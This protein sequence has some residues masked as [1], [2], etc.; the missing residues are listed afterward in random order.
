M[1]NYFKLLLVLLAL[2]TISEASHFRFGTIS[3]QLGPNNVVSFKAD[4]AF[5]R[6]Y[7][8]GNPQVGSVISEGSLN[9][10][11]KSS[12]VSVAMTVTSIDTTQD[13]FTGTFNTQKTYSKDGTY[14]VIYTSCCRI[15]SLKNEADGNWNITTSV[16]IPKSG[17]AINNSPVSGMLPIVPVV[18]G[19][20][21][22]FQVVATDDGDTPTTSN[23]RYALTDV[24]RMTQPG[25]FSVNST[26]YV[27]FTPAAVGLY[28]TQI[29]ITDSQGV[30]IVS[31]FIMSSTKQTGICHPSCNN[32]GSTCNANNDCK[33][34]GAVDGN[35]CGTK[36]PPYFES[37]TPTDGQ[38]L[39][40]NVNVSNTVRIRGVSPYATKNVVITTANVPTGMVGLGSQTGGNPGTMVGTWTPTSSQAG[41][42]VVS[43]GLV[44]SDG[45]SM[46]GGSQSFVIVVGKPV[47]GHGSPVDSGCTSNCACN[48]QAGWDPSFNCFECEKGYYGPECLPNPPCLNGTSN[49]GVGGDGSCSCFFGYTGA[50][51]DTAVSVSCKITDPSSVTDTTFTSGYLYPNSLTAYISTNPSMSALTLPLMV[52]VPYPLPKLDVYILLDINPSN[53][54][55]GNDIKSYAQ[56]FL[57]KLTA[58]CENVNF[59]LGTFS[60]SPI[61]YTFQSKLVIGSPVLDD[62]KSLDV[63]NLYSSSTG[64]SLAAL[65]AAASTSVGWNPG[66]YR[67]M[68]VIT[69]S[70]YA[71]TS[72]TL[73]AETTSVLVSNY[74]T[75]VVV[76]LQQSSAPKWNSFMTSN[77]FG[78]W[79]STSSGTD[80][81]TKAETAVKSAIYKVVGVTENNSDNFVITVPA[82]K[83]ISQTTS[84][85]TAVP[86]TLKYP[87]T[88]VSGRYPTASLSVIGYGKTAV[89]IGYNHVPV[90]NPATFTT[91]EDV[92]LKFTLS[93]TDIDAN[94]LTIKFVSLNGLTDSTLKNG[95]A[96]VSTS[97]SYASGTQFTLVP[98]EDFN[99]A[100]SFTFIVNDGCADSAVATV[101]ITINP[102][103]DVPLCSVIPA[104]STTI[105][106]PGS[107]SLSG[108]DVETATAKL[109]ISIISLAGITPYGTLKSGSTVLTA[110]YST[111]GP[112]AA[113]YTQTSNVD[114]SVSF[115]YRVT[116]ADGASIDCTV[117]MTLKHVNV[118]PTLT[119]PTP[120]STNP[121]NT[122]T[123]SYTAGD[124]DSSS[125]TLQVVSVTA[126]YGSF[127]DCAATPQTITTAYTK[128]LAISNNVAAGQLCYYA[129][130]ASQK[131]GTSLASIT[132]RVTDGSLT[133][134]NVI[135][136]V[137]VVGQRNNEPPTVLQIT[138]KDMNQDTVSGS[139]AIDGTDPDALD[140]GKLQAVILTYPANGNLLVGSASA[141]PQSAAPYTLTYKP[142]AGWYG[143]DSFTYTVTDTLGV[144]A[145]SKTTTVKVI[146]VNHQ[147][148]LYIPAYT[149]TQ[150]TPATASAFSAND[151]DTIDTLT[152]FITKLPTKASISQYD[153][154]PI[155]SAS[156][157]SPA[158][159]TDS[160]FRYIITDNT[161]SLVRYTDSF[162]GICKD[163]WAAGPL[164]SDVA[165]GE[166]TFAYINQ[167]PVASFT[168]VTLDQ[169][170]AKSFDFKVTDL[171]D[172]ALGNAIS[173]KLLTL[174]VNGQLSNN[175][176]AIT[177]ISDTLYPRT[178]TYTPTGKLSNWD[179]P[180]HM[181]PL[182]SISYLAVDSQKL[183]SNSPANVHFNVN[184]QNP[185]VYDG[186]DTVSTLE[187][188]P[189]PIS[190]VG[191]PGNG[192]SSYSITVTKFEGQGVLSATFCMASGEGCM[193][194]PLTY[195]YSV[196]GASLYNFKYTP[197]ANVNGDKL[198][199]ISF[200]L[201][202]NSLVSET[203]KIYVDVIPVNDPPVIIMSNFQVVG[204]D[205]IVPLTNYINMPADSAAIVTYTGYDIDNDN[206]TLVSIIYSLPPQDKGTLHKYNEAA[207]DKIGEEFTLENNVLITG[208]NHWRVVYVPPKGSSGKG[209]SRFALTL[210]DALNAT[211]T[212]VSIS[213]DV[214]P[215]NVAPVINTNTTSYTIQAENSLFIRE[216]SL[217]DP[218]SQEKDPNTF[219]VSVLNADGQVDANSKINFTASQTLVNSVCNF[220]TEANS[221]TCTGNG[222]K[223]NSIISTLTTTHSQEATLTLRVFYDDLGYRGPSRDRL[224]YR[225]N[226]TQDVTITVT[227]PPVKKTNNKTVLSAAI[228]GAAAGAAI[229]AA[230][231]W[232]L[233]R[234]AAPPTDAFF[235]D[236]PFADGAVASNPL[237][238]DSGNS[239]V[240]PFYEA[241][242]N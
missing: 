18:Y 173:V 106:A 39:N 186:S 58:I 35:T 60:D 61:G 42:Y 199:T 135:V 233:L 57:T 88:A 59:G 175:G 48:C 124:T 126:P 167:A 214:D 204:T 109:K 68:V 19:Q 142:K 51:C 197:P 54:N 89:S 220:T 226:A 3:W 200:V 185:P 90:A 75:P 78:G 242:N 231:L 146:H 118:A 180:G 100:Q 50:A 230:A 194:R 4:F 234:K 202:E 62:I 232:K 164:Q 20:Q 30:Y 87:T 16:V 140:Q 150:F 96:A 177:Q 116:D 172:D 10:G 210:R 161:G 24:Y 123:I 131:T 21:N 165:T 113:V 11:D 44:D 86:F 8:G 213:V 98:D 97:V 228:A 156:V 229:I 158:Q 136:N 227:P 17:S 183:Q 152:C 122:T 237:Y 190:I 240:N 108:S 65:K 127:H 32:G 5:R 14:T 49:G 69:D 67:L 120:V 170:T 221:V 26:G 208:T 182:D 166:I 191:H 84:S 119:A 63:S 27:T 25:G 128:T 33:N 207:A 110:G 198:A 211:S 223:L 201:Y 195:P 218:D 143:T 129:S 163:D 157:A 107:I 133:S 241:H 43:L 23:L 132:L 236:N 125:V 144:A 22:G 80:W 93:G 188:N 187:D 153:G 222:V 2:A 206:N 6:S 148:T 105:N 47:C 176:V 77:N 9:F 7:F 193:D 31:D 76:T 85:S 94:I 224:H 71:T 36:L 28:C 159:L 70:D 72:A 37:P 121:L 155:T 83:T 79:T 29:K 13:W 103:N 55:I 171:E 73:A 104:I 141:S 149:F 56:S 66:S 53:A 179:T 216:I 101:S 12:S 239:G 138:L 151:I 38:I 15:S 205:N 81:I 154:T 52:N 115:T 40:M 111:T 145:V 160:Q 46:V 114:A 82:S 196:S 209:F 203:Y 41:R 192:G 225:L 112:I 169:A 212:P 130:D 95:A 238:V 235:G 217:V 99:G 91:D 219:T 137:N 45:M 184:P 74:I 1:N 181:G 189:L 168:N 102:V 147:P 174:P 34:C 215:I 178:L 162:Q 134:S 64:N 139:F 117:P 92:P